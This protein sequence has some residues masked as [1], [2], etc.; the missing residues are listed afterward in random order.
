MSDKKKVSTLAIS[1]AILSARI[2]LEREL[3]RVW[4]NLILDSNGPE[5][6][7]DDFKE[8]AWRYFDN[9]VDGVKSLVGDLPLVTEDDLEPEEPEGPEE[10][11]FGYKYVTK[12]PN[13]G[14][15]MS[16]RDTNDP[17]KEQTFQDIF[18]PPGCGRNYGGKI[19]CIW[20]DGETMLV[21]D[22]GDRHYHGAWDDKRKWQPGCG[23]GTTALCE[24]YAKV[25]THPEWMK[26]Y[27]NEIGKD[28]PGD[29]PTESDEWRTIRWGGDQSLGFGG[30]DSRD[31]TWWTKIHGSH[32]TPW[33]RKF[34]LPKEVE[35]WPGIQFE[36]SDGSSLYVPNPKKMA[37]N[38]NGP[39]YRPEEPGEGDSRKQHPKVGAI[40]KSPVMWVKY[41]KR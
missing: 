34:P 5:V 21:S 37:M 31:R 2:G 39:K 10:P 24:A 22:A 7:K 41:K 1:I 17:S 14:E 32:S 36:F 11:M 15:K 33:S 12:V 3:D 28:K 27:H 38:T 6:D 26:I 18:R 20:S 35:G 8:L 19:M 29:Q 30:H 23:D 16:H 9:A 40:P 25:G 4:D 13:S